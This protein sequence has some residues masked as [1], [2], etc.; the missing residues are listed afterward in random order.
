VQAQEGGESVGTPQPIRNRWPAVRLGSPCSSGPLT[1]FPILNGSVALNDYVLLA[2]AVEKGLAKV[3][4]LSERGDI[5]VIQIENLAEQPVL[6]IQGE[7]YVGAKQNRT[8]NISVLAARGKTRIPVT[9]V[10]AGRWDTGSTHFVA[11]L[12]ESSKMRAMKMASLHKSSKSVKNK[13]K[14]F[15][16]DQG[17]VWDAVREESDRRGVGSP[18]MAMHDIYSSRDVFES[19]GAIAAGIDVPEETR[20]A[21]VG[22]GSRLIGCDLFE[23]SGVFRRTWPRLLRSYGLS[24]LGE[25]GAPPSVASAQSFFSRPA[26]VAPRTTASV[27]LGDDVRWEDKD[28][29][30]N[31]LVW[32]DRILHAT[33]FARDAA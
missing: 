9:C 2:D 17:Q 28:F 26:F 5:P 15:F 27:G 16:A 32:E 3:T 19:L 21:V 24:A 11:G 29:L 8:L 1:V 30:A 10:E 18:T 25:T 23:S 14:K 20:G 33:V 22:I 4:E 13:L 7:E 31:A 6:G 12:Y